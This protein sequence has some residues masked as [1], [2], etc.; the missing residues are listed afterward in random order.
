[1]KPRLTNDILPALAAV[2]HDDVAR[3]KP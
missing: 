3:A 1:M 2:L